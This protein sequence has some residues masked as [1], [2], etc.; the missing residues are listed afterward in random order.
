MLLCL[1]ALLLLKSLFSLRS[2][3]VHVGFELSLKY[4]VVV[5]ALLLIPV[6]PDLFPKET[7]SVRFFSVGQ[8]DASLL[9]FP[10]GERWLI[11]GGPD[12][13]VLS[14]LGQSLPW[15]ERR[16]DVLIPTHADADH[17]TGLIEVARRYDIGRVYLSVDDANVRMRMLQEALKDVPKI[18]VRAGDLLQDGEVR[19]AV[20][21]PD[22][23]EVNA[24]DRNER[25][26]VL[27]VESEGR[28]L[29]FTGDASADI[30]RRFVHHLGKVD[31]YKAGHHGSYT[32]SSYEL[33]SR[34]TP[35]IAIISS[36]EENRYGHPHGVVL[37]RLKAV[38]A[39]ILRTDTMGDIEVIVSGGGLEVERGRLWY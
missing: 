39:E 19:V 8:G 36:G 37:E 22:D 38:G 12:N 15:Y 4:F 7:F 14:K 32:S 5:G 18:T 13:T 2:V 35:S 34:M 20:L 33:L 31:V 6:V 21:A 27:L 30:E 24:L 1:L 10:S 3:P 28:S 26:V 29:L 11:D 9:R 23:V 17:I 16:I 25:S